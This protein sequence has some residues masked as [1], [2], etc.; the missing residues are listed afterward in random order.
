MSNFILKHK[1]DQQIN[2]LTLDWIKAKNAET[3]F[4]DK[5]HKIEADI[6]ELTGAKENGSGSVIVDNGVKVSF[7]TTRKWD[8]D[9]VYNNIHFL[10]NLDGDQCPFTYVFKED[11]KKMDA[12]MFRHR[13]LY[14]HITKGLTETIAKPTFSINKKGGE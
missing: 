7:K 4:K 10:Q 6:I 14:D 1:L 5:R 3:E 11:K 2:Q 12:L 8:N 9:H 13:D